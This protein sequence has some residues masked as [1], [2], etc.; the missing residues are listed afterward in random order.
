MLSQ[1]LRLL[2]QQ[3]G[4]LGAREISR[5]LG[6]P[7]SALG[8][9]LDLLVSQGRLARIEPCAT[10]CGTC[11]AQSDCNLLASRQPRYVLIRRHRPADFCRVDV[12]VRP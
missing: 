10:A 1:V 2:E 4:G 9:M 7:P 12:E 11:P 5:R 8:G 6:V 3:H